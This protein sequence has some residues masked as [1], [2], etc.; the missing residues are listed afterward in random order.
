[1]TAETKTEPTETTP[2]KK[3]NNILSSENKKE[4]SLWSYLKMISKVAFVIFGFM[5][6]GSTW[7]LFKQIDGW[8][9]IISE[10]EIY[11]IKA[12]SLTIPKIVNKIGVLSP[13]ERRQKVV[14][15]FELT[16]KPSNGLIYYEEGIWDDA[17]FY[18]ES[19]FIKDGF[20]YTV[21]HRKWDF[22]DPVH[23]FIRRDGTNSEEELNSL[24]YNPNGLCLFVKLSSEIGARNTY[25]PAK[26][27]F[28]VGITKAQKVC[29]ETLLLVNNYL[30]EN[31]K[32]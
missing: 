10:E 31:K 7:Y 27:I 9:V 17:E 3:R 16:K 29:D 25:Y 12:D 18:S 2:T 20:R 32:G 8:R 4:K 26:K 5:S 24:Y 13:N 11:A 23:I 6:I 15:V 30:N 19:V 28:D 14:E 1:M 22:N 21:K